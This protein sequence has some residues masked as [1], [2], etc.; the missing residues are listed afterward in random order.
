[1]PVP[2]G[3]SR[4]GALGLFGLGAGFGLAGLRILLRKEV[5]RLEQLAEGMDLPVLGAAGEL[6]VPG[7]LLVRS[8]E[9]ATVALLLAAYAG[10]SGS[11]AYLYHSNP[12]R[13]VPA[14]VAGGGAD[15]LGVRLQ[16]IA[17]I[18][19]YLPHGDAARGSE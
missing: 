17:A 19:P 10:C 2:E 16:G 12:A 6:R 11:L 5:L 3:L 9:F 1:M 18:L 4:R 13:A 15:W 14:P 8:A 7:A